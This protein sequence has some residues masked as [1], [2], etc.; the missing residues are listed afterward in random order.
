MITPFDYA[1]I[2][3][4]LLG[5]LY[6]GI[7][8]TG[9]QTDVVDYFLG[10]RNFPWWAACLSVVATETSTLTFIGV[11]AI[12]YGGTMTFLQ[13]TFG[14][15]LGRI[16]VSIW[17][18]PRYFQGNLSTA[19]A[20]LGEQ[21]G[22]KMRATASVT[23]MITRL[24]AD[25]V[26]LFATAI[27]LKMIAVSANIEI[28]YFTII[29]II[30]VA[31]IAYTLVGGL[32]AVVWVDVVQVTV[33]MVGGVISIAVLASALPSDWWAVAGAAG[34]T[35]VFNFGVGESLSMW[36]TTPYNFL[37]ASVGG[38]VYAMASHGTDQFIVQRLLACRNL[39][40]S[41]RALI[42]SGIIIIVQTALF[43]SVGLLLWVYYDG[44][45]VGSLGLSRT[46]EIFPRFIIESLP[47]GISGILIASIIAAAMSSL[48]SSLN[49][50]ASSSVMDL[51]QR[52]KGYV[53]EDQTLFVSRAFTL[54][55]GL[56]FI[57]FASMFQDQQTPV[58]ELGLSIATFSF[59]GLLGVFL[60]GLA[61]QRASQKNSIIAFSSALLI[62][63]LLF[64]GLGYSPE[65]GWQ[66]ALN[67]SVYGASE[68]KVRG[69][70]WPW[71][72]VIVSSTTFVLGNLLFNINKK[73][74]V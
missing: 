19:Y 61:Q 41:R 32:T 8:M 4:Y 45:S 21:F 60:L 6:L 49:S 46:D 67:S 42:G 51:Y 59:G 27:P 55:W 3:L 72:T 11:P 35:N 7:Y 57:V 24:L 23:F 20:F 25:G 44:A 34:K 17:L 15:L 69:I 14:Y 9:R 30:G 62:T 29:F 2:I 52:F 48:S 63:L 1:I 64:I 12:A 16:L 43:L 26:K 33:Y 39:R 71:Y 37:T 38:T 58:V 68:G 47:T 66:F 54:L 74:I 40:D 28:S 53:G 18:L 73:W 10:G 56:V 22:D 50:L 65:D 31:T 13:L 36:V 70:A 5:T